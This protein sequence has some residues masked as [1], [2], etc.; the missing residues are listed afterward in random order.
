MH[1]VHVSIHVKPECVEEFKKATI[2]N[3]SNSA[4]EPG[5]A[6]F[7]FIQQQDD[8]TRFMLVEVYNSPDDVAKHKETA[9][10]N[11][12][13]AKVSDMLDGERTRIFYT[14]IFPEDAR[15]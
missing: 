14:N 11:N 7:D 15:W 3:A 2:V 10:Y 6:R 9:H 1:I 8:P 13:V 4:Q 12:W 5:I